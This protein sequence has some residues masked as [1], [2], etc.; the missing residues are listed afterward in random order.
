M[1]LFDCDSRPLARA[2]IDWLPH[3][4]LKGGSDL[5]RCTAETDEVVRRVHHW[6]KVIEVIEVH[7]TGQAI[8]IVALQDT[9]APLQPGE[10]HVPWGLSL[11]PPSENIGKTV[12]QS[13]AER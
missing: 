3:R 9:V 4:C 12:N 13:I 11:D 5:V 1:V 2:C 8:A 7:G 10:L 6:A